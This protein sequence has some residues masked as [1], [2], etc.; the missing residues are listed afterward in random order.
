MQGCI[1]MQLSV[2]TGLNLSRLIFEN[3]A[4]A[5]KPDRNHDMVAMDVH[6]HGKYGWLMVKLRP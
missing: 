4:P 6:Y 1:M 5:P 2:S 3:T